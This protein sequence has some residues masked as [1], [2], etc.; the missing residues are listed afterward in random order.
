[1][2]IAM[3]YGFHHFYGFFI[4]FLFPL[5]PEVENAFDLSQEQQQQLLREAA[6]RYWP[7]VIAALVSDWRQ[8][9]RPLS[10]PRL[11]D[12]FRP[13]AMLVRMHLFIFVA[14]A[15]LLLAGAGYLFYLLI[16]LFFFFPW[17]LIWQHLS[18][19][20]GIHPASHRRDKHRHD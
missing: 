2:L 1:M 14:I 16:L 5:W 3:V 6:A 11:T 13:W 8:L 19:R 18:A 12:L 9:L 20:R 4:Y 7:F 17:R 10:D 15:V